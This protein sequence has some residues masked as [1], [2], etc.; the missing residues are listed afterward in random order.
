M[1]NAAL[2]TSV[3]S[4]IISLV[5]KYVPFVAKWYYDPARDNVRGLIMVGLMALITGGYYFL[6]PQFAQ[7]GLTPITWQEGV[8]A[9]FIALGS[10][11]LTDRTT[12]YSP[13]KAEIVAEEAVG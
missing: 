5:A 7:F 12:P 6:A 10:N 8:V 9:F 13:T 11:Q 4:I 3:L 1:F 2:I